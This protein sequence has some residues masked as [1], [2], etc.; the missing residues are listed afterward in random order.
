MRS[1]SSSSKCKA[2]ERVIII[3][4]DLLYPGGTITPT[5]QKDASSAAGLTA[6]SIKFLELSHVVLI[7]GSSNNS[8]I[9]I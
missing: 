8:L 1:T 9:L 5:A 2:K 6:P 4:V 7:P 3:E